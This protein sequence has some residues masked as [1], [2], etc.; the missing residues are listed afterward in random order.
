MRKIR[1]WIEDMID[2]ISRIEEFT[3]DY[4]FEEFLRI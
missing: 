1:N 2:A 4:S 3:A